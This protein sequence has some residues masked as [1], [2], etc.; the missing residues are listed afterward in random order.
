MALVEI[1]EG[2]VRVKV[3]NKEALIP[4]SKGKPKDY[5]WVEKSEDEGLLILI[6][7]RG[8]R[9]VE[10]YYPEGGAGGV[11]EDSY[12]IPFKR[13]LRFLCKSSWGVLLV[14]ERGSMVVSWLPY[15]GPSVEMCRSFS[16]F[17]LGIKDGSLVVFFPDR[18]VE[19]SLSLSNFTVRRAFLKGKKVI[20]FL[21]SDRDYRVEVDIERGLVKSSLEMDLNAFSKHKGEVERYGD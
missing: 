20:I 11:R 12:F 4:L 6:Y 14:F 3:G 2:N 19:V 21:S 10:L 9:V 15:E 18:Y 5:L 16:H 13:E 17:F 7:E 8:V 1:V